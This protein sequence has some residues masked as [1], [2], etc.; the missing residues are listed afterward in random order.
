VTAE[1]LYGTLNIGNISFS[2]CFE[3]ITQ[4]SRYEGGDTESIV[5]RHVAKEDVHGLVKAP[6]HADHHCEADV[7][8][9]CEDVDN[10]EDDE[11][12]VGRLV[13]DV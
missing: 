1:R 8:H 9:H 3:N 12:R 5:E 4:H 6:L 11:G 10:K 2:T 7:G 13:G